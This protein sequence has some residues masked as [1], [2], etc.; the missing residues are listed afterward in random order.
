MGELLEREREGSLA[1]GVEVL[2]LL[3]GEANS[4]E[5]VLTEVELMWRMAEVER[6]E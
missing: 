3:I 4:G 2:R 5:E 6:E 1:S